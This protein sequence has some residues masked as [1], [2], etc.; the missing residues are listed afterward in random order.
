MDYVEFL[1]W[2]NAFER[3]VYLD[4]DEEGQGYSRID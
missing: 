4:L 2:L 3:G 1:V